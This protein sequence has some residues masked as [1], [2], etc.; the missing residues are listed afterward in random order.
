MKKE[1][2]TPPTPEAP[3]PN[4]KTYFAF[5][6]CPRNLFEVETIKVEGD[7][8]IEV[9]KDEPTFLPIALD[10]VRRSIASVF[11]SKVNG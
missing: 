10:K 9:I 2:L 3:A 5:N 11:S 7:K 1:K 8:V 4:V 6:L